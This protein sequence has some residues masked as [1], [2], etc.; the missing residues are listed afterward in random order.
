MAE[1]FLFPFSFSFFS[2]SSMDR[3]SILGSLI[4]TLEQGA[5]R[6]GGFEYWEHGRAKYTEYCRL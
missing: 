3:A 6:E 2:G 5:W 4:T 1:T